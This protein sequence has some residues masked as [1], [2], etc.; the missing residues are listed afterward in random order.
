[1]EAFTP[2][3]MVD[4]VSTVVIPADTERKEQGFVSP[5]LSSFAQLL[6]WPRTSP[7]LPLQLLTFPVLAFMKFLL[8]L[9]SQLYP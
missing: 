2:V 9:C 8:L 3:M 7:S 4:M 5:C 1:M 6:L